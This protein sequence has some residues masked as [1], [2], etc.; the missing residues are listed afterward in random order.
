M[1]TN[2][3]HETAQEELEEKMACDNEKLEIE[4]QALLDKL[5]AKI[6]G[7]IPRDALDFVELMDSAEDAVKIL[8][9]IGGRLCE[10]FP[11]INLVEPYALPDEVKRLDSTIDKY[12]FMVARFPF[13][14][15]ICALVVKEDVD[16]IVIH[17]YDLE[18][19]VPIILK[20]DGSPV[21]VY[22]L[23]YDNHTLEVPGN[24]RFGMDIDM[25]EGMP[26]KADIKELLLNEFGSYVEKSKE[27]VKSAP[28]LFNNDE[29][30]KAVETWAEN[31]SYKIFPVLYASIDF[32]H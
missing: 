14:A 15:L 32:F 25:T 24:L 7:V 2:D 8:W 9:K 5:C 4:K 21:H 12:S 18:S 31:H 22:L 20:K 17:A 11:N 16:E 30:K 27:Y 1:K 13:Q 28:E 19:R 6:D 3:K 26:N 29:E 10:E 23:N